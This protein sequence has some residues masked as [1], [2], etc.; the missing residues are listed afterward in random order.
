MEGELVCPTCGHHHLI[1]RGKVYSNAST[2][3]SWQCMNCL[4]YSKTPTA[5]KARLGLRPL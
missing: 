4:R 5:N 3:Q 1:K 2:W